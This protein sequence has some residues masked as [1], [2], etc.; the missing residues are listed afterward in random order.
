MTQ[1]LEGEKR[2]DLVVRW[3]RPYRRDAK[4]IGAITVAAPDGTLVPLS[5]LAS[6]TEEESPSK[7]WREDQQRYAPVKFSIR[8]RDLA[9]AINE[10]KA[11]IAAKVKLPYGTRLE[12]AGEINELREAEQRLLIIV[13]ITVL[14]IVFLVYSATRNWRDSLIVLINIPV[15][16]AGGIL[17]LLLTGENFSVSAAMGFVSIFGIAIQDAILVVTYAQRKWAEG[18]TIEE[19]ARAAAVQRLRASL[20]TTLVAMFGLLPAALSRGIGAQAQRPLA[21][22]VI[23][24]AFVLAFLTRVLQP[25]LLV[26][27]H[28]RREKGETP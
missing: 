22:V 10:A 12:W 2:F 14:M 13:P 27:A 15:A 28:R 20:M 21:I 4:A 25:P 16:C 26:L 5:Q 8:G 24:G 3:Q 23:G 6:I 17:A 1:V 7:I 9:G 11:R 18:M 19:G